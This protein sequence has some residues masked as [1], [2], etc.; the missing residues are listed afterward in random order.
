MISIIERK[1]L[2]WPCCLTLFHYSIKFLFFSLF[3]LPFFFLF[4]SCHGN[5]GMKIY[6]ICV[7]CLSMTWDWIQ[8]SSECV[9]DQKHFSFINGSSCIRCP[10]GVRCMYGA[11]TSGYIVYSY[12]YNIYILLP[13][14]VND[15]TKLTSDLT[16]N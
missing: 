10:W 14:F 2:I 13:L 4:V 6:L 12:I 7:H 3:F 5:L 16:D 11:S 9:I 1:P 8:I 15:N